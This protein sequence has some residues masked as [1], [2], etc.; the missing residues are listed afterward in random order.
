MN[1]NGTV[2]PCA[3]DWQ[4][5]LTVGDVKKESLKKYGIQIN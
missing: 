1:S 2:S 5:K 3:L 4:E